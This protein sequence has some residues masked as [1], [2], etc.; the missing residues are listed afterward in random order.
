MAGSVGEWALDVYGPYPMDTGTPLLNP[1][2][3]AT[4]SGGVVRGG[5]FDV[6]TTNLVRAAWREPYYDQGIRTHYIGFRCAR[7]TP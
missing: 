2:S 7:A 6:T 5:A 1:I 4:G 3:A